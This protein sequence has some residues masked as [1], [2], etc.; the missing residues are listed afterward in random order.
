MKLF[1]TGSEAVF[2]ECLKLIIFLPLKYQLVIDLRVT[3]S[4]SR[5]QKIISVMCLPYRPLEYV[6][7]NIMHSLFGD[8]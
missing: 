8:C 2:A 6:L 5:Q 7:A 1:R 4:D 3:R